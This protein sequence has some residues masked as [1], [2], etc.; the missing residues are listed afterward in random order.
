MCLGDRHVRWG[1]AG[2]S[3]SVGTPALQV[4]AL[5]EGDG[6]AF[7]VAAL[8]DFDAVAGVEDL[9]EGNAALEQGGA[10]GFDVGDAKDDHRRIFA[11]AA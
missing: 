11:N 3:R 1:R 5:F 6:V 4:R 9:F 7:G 2:E 10:C 8:D